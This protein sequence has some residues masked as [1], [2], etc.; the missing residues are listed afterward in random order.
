MSKRS[1]RKRKKCVD[2]YITDHLAKYAR[3]L[4]DSCASTRVVPQ[5]LQLKRSD[6]NGKYA[7][8]RSR[9]N[10]KIRVDA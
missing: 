8:T 2:L 7:S 5:R 9:R 10:R 4:Y 6:G 3:I 1:D